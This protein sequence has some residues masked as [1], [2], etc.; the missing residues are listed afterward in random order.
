MN[1]V[2]NFYTTYGIERR[3]ILP[4]PPEA[5]KLFGSRLDKDISK[6]LQLRI[7]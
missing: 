3:R 2:N 4:Y 6:I 1:Q 7:I 5:V